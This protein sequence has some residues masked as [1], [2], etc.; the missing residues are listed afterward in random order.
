[1]PKSVFKCPNTGMNIPRPFTLDPDAD[2]SSY[3]LVPCPACALSHLIN[4]ATGSLMGEPQDEGTGRF[5]TP[6]PKARG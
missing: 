5:G 1:M 2:P 4:K 6:N 3:E